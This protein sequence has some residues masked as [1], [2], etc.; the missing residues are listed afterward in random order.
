MVGMGIDDRA[1]TLEEERPPTALDA[2][3]GT[4]VA[5]LAVMACPDE[6]WRVGEVALLTLGDPSGTRVFGRGPAQANDSCPRLSFARVTA[7]GIEAALPIGV[8]RISRVQAYVTRVGPCTLRVQ[9]V[10][11]CELLHN[12]RTADVAMVRPGDTVQ[13]GRQVLLLSVLRRPELR[14]PEDAYLVER[15]GHAD[16]FGL[17]G[18]SDAL[19]GLRH[20]I[21]FVAARRGHVL[22]T[23]TSGTGKE[24]VAGAVHALSERRTRP[25]VTRNAAT[26][27]EGIVDAE[28][29]GNARNYPHQGMAERPGLIGQAD[30]STL[31]L[32]EFA[33]LPGAVQPHLLRVLDNGEY[34]RLGES[35]ARCSD[36]RLLAATNRP[37]E[38]IKEDLL[39]RFAFRIDVPDL[40]ARREDIPFLARHL[41]RRLGTRDANIAARVFPASDVDREPSLSFEFVKKL[42]VH[43][44][45]TNVRE[46]ETL[47]LR[48]IESN[49]S[50]PL[51]GEAAPE[52]A[53]DKTAEA[54][55]PPSDDPPVVEDGL[56]S[57]SAA[58]IQAALDESNGSVEG[59]WRALGL[60]NRYVLR[61][62][63][64][65]HGIEIRR[66]PKNR[67]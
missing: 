16:P 11:R 37:I 28:L 20:R 46:L 12:D 38:F 67:R 56:A 39:A 14:R 66:K 58:R 57:L 5:T 18:E 36:F 32:D 60:S 40:N 17:V 21:R 19:W 7:D 47:L 26:L 64:A 51:G 50:G 3:E 33:E 25:M 27:P 30:G 23:G 22:I 2:L 43:S 29:F 24:L 15:F 9:N 52:H 34:H 44:Y 61:R 13:F 49:R 41:L 45:R 6:P 65:K 1:S 59:A 8:R 53:C 62:L 63:I 35:V 48:A 31:F 10:G 54:D 55:L 42:V 4:A